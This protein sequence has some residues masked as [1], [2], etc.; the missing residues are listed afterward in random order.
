RTDVAGESLR[1]IQSGSGFYFENSMFHSLPLLHLKG[2]QPDSFSYR[3][4]KVSVTSAEVG[5]PACS[6][7]AQRPTS[8]HQSLFRLSVCFV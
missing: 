8:R 2:Y 6:G 1:K 4:L 3:F 7:G 5:S